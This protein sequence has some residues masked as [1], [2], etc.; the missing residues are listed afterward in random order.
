V[1]KVRKQDRMTDSRFKTGSILRR[2]EI[3]IHNLL[4]IKTA[5]FEK[6]EV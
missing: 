4:W 2:G 3:F 6:P 5:I 1:E